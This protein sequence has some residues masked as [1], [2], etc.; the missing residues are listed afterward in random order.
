MLKVKDFFWVDFQEK[1]E[2][3]GQVQSVDGD[4]RH[5]RVLWAEKRRAARGAHAAHTPPL[6]APTLE[7]DAGEAGDEVVGPAPDQLCQHD[8]Q[9]LHHALRLGTFQPGAHR[10]QQVW[11]ERA[12]CRRGDWVWR[13]CREGNVALLGQ[14]DSQVRDCAVITNALLQA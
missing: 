9:R 4:A 14:G 11:Q 6:P 7:L 2:I 13:R 5:R 10:T 3:W 8:Q 12:L 1:R